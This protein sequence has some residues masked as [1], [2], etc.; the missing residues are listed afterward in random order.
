VS[1]VHGDGRLV[2]PISLSTYGPR[3]TA[4]DVTL[5]LGNGEMTIETMKLSK[6]LGLREV[7]QTIK[8]A[9]AKNA[10]QSLPLKIQLE[11]KITLYLT[12]AS[13]DY[14]QA[15]IQSTNLAF[16]MLLQE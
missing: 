15:D 14:S 2:G 12:A 10:G 3:N 8:D 9:E 1:S 4:G 5:T 6:R 13:F 16:W 11:G 7:M